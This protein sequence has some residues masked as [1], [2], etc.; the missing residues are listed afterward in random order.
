MA[1]N[2]IHRCV[3]SNGNPVF[4]DQPCTSQDATPAVAVAAVA[5]T[6]ANAPGAPA[7]VPILCATSTADLRRAVAEAFAT[8]DAN[9]LSGLVLWN[10]YSGQGAIADIQS[11]SALLRQTLLDFGAPDARQENGEPAANHG[12]L[13]RTTSS[14]GS[15]APMDTHFGVVRQA[16]C[17][18]LQP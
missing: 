11:L 3:G 8:K 16:G 14:D 1:Q 6:A 15:G 5:A 9:R 10:G 2:E 17:L 13:V 7:A 18:W 4:S 12:L